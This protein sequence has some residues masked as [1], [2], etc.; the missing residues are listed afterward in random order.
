MSAIQEIEPQAHIIQLAQDTISGQFSP[1]AMANVREEITN[2][3]IENQD[4]R[5]ISRDRYRKSIKQYFL[6]INEKGLELKN[7]TRAE[8]L[9]Y[10]DELMASGLSPLTAGAYIT[11]VRKFYEWAESHKL[12]PNV[13]RG[14]KTPK[15]ENKFLKMHLT[16][17]QCNSL[18]DYFKT[19]SLR[20]QAIVSTLL[21][22]GIRTVE[23]T[24]LNVGDIIQKSGRRILRIQGKGHDRKDAF[25]ILTEKAYTPIKAYLSGWDAL[26]PDDPVFVSESDKNVGGRLTTRTISFIVKKGLIAIGLNSDEYTAHSLRHTAAVLMLKAGAKMERLQSVLRHKKIDTTQIYTASIDDELRFEDA[27][28]ELLD[29]LF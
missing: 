1:V 9:Q 29:S 3:F 18:V 8:I 24:R 13:A 7:I 10:K 5:Q 6:W 21:R 16:Q 17:E 28:E 19:K 27:P 14:V 12:Y 4:V 15:R 26:N 11:A 23:L 25:V 22:T 20:D 2:K